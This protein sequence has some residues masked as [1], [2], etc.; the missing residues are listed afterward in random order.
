MDEGL[1]FLPV[2]IIFNFI[3]IFIFLGSIQSRYN[4]LIFSSTLFRIVP[5]RIIKT[6]MFSF[7]E[8]FINDRFH[9][10]IFFCSTEVYIVTFTLGY[11]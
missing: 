5:V 6:I 4:T 9:V 1:P 8:I 3:F 7:L 2:L 10:V 11:L